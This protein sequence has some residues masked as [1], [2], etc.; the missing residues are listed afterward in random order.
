M[1]K[2]LSKLLLP[3]LGLTLA[4]TFVG[5][6][7][8]ST[9]SSSSSSS[10]TSMVEKLPTP[11]L[12][13]YDG[14]TYT[15]EDTSYTRAYIYELNGVQT[16]V[17]NPASITLNPG[18]TLR[19]K[20]L[21]S[22]E[23]YYQDSDWSEM[24]SIQIKH[25][26]ITFESEI[27]GLETY[28]EQYVCKSQ[29][30]L[31]KP[32]I[33]GYTFS[34]WY[35]KGESKDHR[36]SQVSNFWEEDVTLVAHFIPKEYRITYNNYEVKVNYTTGDWGTDID[37]GLSTK[38]YTLNSERQKYPYALPDEFELRKKNEVFAGWYEDPEL[39]TLFDFEKYLTEDVS[40]YPKIIGYDQLHYAHDEGTSY[41]ISGNY[42]NYKN[43]YTAYVGPGSYLMDPDIFTFIAHVD[44]EIKLFYQRSD[45]Y[46]DRNVEMTI[47]NETTKTKIATNSANSYNWKE[48]VLNVNK[49]DLISIN[50]DSDSLAS[51]DKKVIMYIT[52]NEIDSRIA[53]V[54]N[55]VDVTYGEEFVIPFYEEKPG[56][57]F[58][59]YFTGENGTGSQMTDEEG[60]SLQGYNIADN[61]TLYPHY[62]LK[63]FSITYH[64][65]DGE[66][67]D[68]AIYDEVY[69]SLDEDIILP[70]LTK[71]GYTFDGWYDNAFFNGEAITKIEKGSTGDKELY[72]KFTLLTLNVDV[73][74]APITVNFETFGGEEIA[75]ITISKE[76][77]TLYPPLPK[78]EGYLFAGWYLDEELNL[79]YDFSYPL[80][81]DE[82]LYAKFISKDEALYNDV[83]TDIEYE[84]IDDVV[85]DFVVPASSSYEVSY[86]FTFTAKEAYGYQY[87]IKLYEESNANIDF[88]IYNETT[89]EYIQGKNP[90]SSSYYLCT[91]MTNQYD[92]ISVYCYGRDSDKNINI[93]VKGDESLNA[94]ELKYFEEK[95]IEY[96][97]TYNLPVYKYDNLS[98]MGYYTEPNGQG[99]KLTNELGECLSSWDK[100]V[101]TAVYAYYEAGVINVNYD[102][103][104]GRL[105][106]D[107][108]LPESIS[109]YDSYVLPEAALLGHSF[110]YWY[111]D[112]N[113]EHEIITSVDSSIGN[114]V[115]IKAYFE[116]NKYKV[117][118]IYE[119]NPELN[120]E[121]EVYYGEKYTVSV[122]ELEGKSLDGFYSRVNG[123][124]NLEAS[125]SSGTSF[126][127]YYSES[128]TVIYAKYTLYNYSIYYGFDGG[129]PVTPYEPLETYTIETDHELPELTKEYHTFLGWYDG[130]DTLI[131][132]LLGHTGT[133][134][135]NAKF[136]ADEFD[137]TVNM[138]GYSIG[139]PNTVYFRHNDNIP[140]DDTSVKVTPYVGLKYFEP[141]ELS[142]YIFTGW[143]EYGEYYDFSKTIDFTVY[144]N[145]NWETVNGDGT[146]SVYRSKTINVENNVTLAFFS[147]FNEEVTI[148]LTNQEQLKYRIIKQDGTLILE[149]SNK[150]ELSFLAEE[151]QIYYLQITNETNEAVL[152]TVSLDASK[153]KDGGVSYKI[154]EVFVTSVPYNGGVNIEVC[155]YPCATFEGY[156]TQPNG[157]GEQIT[158][159]TGFVIANVYEG[160]TLYPYYEIVPVTIYYQGY[161]DAVTATGEPLVTEMSIFDKLVLPE[162]VM[163]GHVFEGWFIAN[164]SED[165]KVEVI[166]GE[167][168]SSG[169]LTLNARFERIQVDIT[170]G[171]IDSVITFEDGEGN[172]LSKQILNENN[173]Y[174]EYPEIP[175]K[176]GYVFSGWIH[177]YGSGSIDINLAYSYFGSVTL[178][179]KWKQAAYLYK[180]NV[181]SNTYIYAERYYEGNSYNIKVSKDATEDNPIRIQMTPMH[182]EDYYMYIKSTTDVTLSLYDEDY[183]NLIIEPVEITSNG[184][185]VKYSLSEYGGNLLSLHLYGAIEDGES[186]IYF[187]GLYHADTPTGTD[188]TFE[189]KVTYG[190]T[191][192]VRVA[193]KENY[194]FKGYFTEPNGE[195]KQI[196]D[197]N[198]YPID[199]S[200]TL[201]EDTVIYAYYELIAVVVEETTISYR[202]KIELD[203][204]Q[205]IPGEVTIKYYDAQGNEVIPFEVG[206]YKVVVSYESEEYGSSVV[207]SKLIITNPAPQTGME[208]YGRN[209]VD[210]EYRAAS[211]TGNDSLVF[212]DS[213]VLEGGIN[214]KVTMIDNGLFMYHSQLEEVV[215]GDTIN[216]ITYGNF[217]GTS[218]TKV[219]YC[220]TEEQWNNIEIIEE[221]NEPLLEAT[222]YFY[223]KEAPKEAG[224]YW[225]Y[226]DGKPTLWN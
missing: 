61:A 2:K 115:T 81:K 17:E 95:E 172:E 129:E 149:T 55:F 45:A 16:E 201:E 178:E 67:A 212:V 76:N 64:S 30:E 158:T 14:V 25:I 215:I 139:F 59:G 209:D 28:T 131:E 31:P 51:G 54:P 86:R 116:L 79:L 112:N 9:S 196:T 213:Y 147:Y 182:Y 221:G 27:A 134:Y 190:Y 39:T 187:D 136:K 84:Y 111:I 143:T 38:E 164:T 73:Y 148:N 153:V 60:K 205:N 48:V 180:E 99:T 77:P 122:H 34:H 37:Y 109:I 119:D 150:E 123:S 171:G 193:E 83:K 140:F 169:R 188:D 222:L 21:T 195:G 5:C 43:Y 120:E 151:H 211:Y 142:G 177:D 167:L 96:G 186:E 85:Y 163:K 210:N 138:E 198:G 225:H 6:G 110:K 220:G 53:G 49:G 226:V 132:N 87:V 42:N 11:V 184:E 176:E 75:P 62:Q 35:I 47:Y 8:A 125:S 18:D 19:V 145:S 154:D 127:Y 66:L 191:Y 36:Y 160:M 157:Q 97:S 78:K 174:L 173:L 114:N 69:T 70:T 26:N 74:L 3:L 156:Y 92:V 44:G 216:Y 23:I 197:V 102:L 33:D 63:E 113:G 7:G 168:L 162:M 50:L 94:K 72:A 155:E 128:D 200:W 192:N 217:S 108:T 124:E 218:L 91:F 117:T 88:V 133:L 41:Y 208:Y 71:K 24:V 199:G 165:I 179:A 4:F 130:N 194:E 107:E 224:N 90:I 103:C 10:S 189:T 13:S 68:G 105:L 204:T 93:A 101:D 65:D 141:E 181:Y 89:K 166:S 20:A 146:F 98:F 80:I 135:I 203:Y 22:Q 32:T 175:T 207:E 52:G 219:Y 214:K 58:L 29:E 159:N 56:Y 144:L 202:E 12:T 121:V 161:E 185:Y 106:N 126:N 104:G 15:W 137:V 223:S 1:K 57:E 82:T 152:T 206:E 46:N 100:D 40:I 118:V 183:G 170:L